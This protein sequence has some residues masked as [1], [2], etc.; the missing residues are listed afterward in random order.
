MAPGVSYS[1]RM[2]L[3]APDLRLLFPLAANLFDRVEIKR[4]MGH[5]DEIRLAEHPLLLWCL[6]RIKL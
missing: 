1:K 3:L 4:L 2:K 5:E 6:R